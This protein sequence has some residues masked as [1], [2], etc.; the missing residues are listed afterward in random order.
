MGRVLPTFLRSDR[1]FLLR[2]IRFSFTSAQSSFRPTALWPRSACCLRSCWRNAPRA[3]VGVDPNKIWN[4]CIVC[5]LYCACRLASASRHRQLANAAPS[6]ALAA[7]P[8]NDSSPARR[9][10]CRALCNRRG[11]RSTHVGNGCRCAARL[12]RSLLRSP[13]DSPSSNSARSSPAPATAPRAALPWAVT[14]TDPLA[15]RWS[16]APLGI[17]VHPVQAY[18]AL[19]FLTISICLLLLLPSRRQH[20]D[21]AGVFLIVKRRRDIR[22]RVLARSGRPRRVLTVH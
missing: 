16:G 20:G 17:P 2:C 1:L 21:V 9:R 3:R 22:H 7:Q 14:Y 18:A 4:L 6:S 12:M 19:R 5:P 15:A 13:S 11:V 10:I 8:R